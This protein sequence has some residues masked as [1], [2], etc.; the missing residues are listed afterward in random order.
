MSGA[1]M[2]ETQAAVAWER[3]HQ[4]LANSQP[5]HRPEALRISASRD[6]AVSANLAAKLPARLRHAA[7]L[8]ALIDAPEA[9]GI[10]LTVRAAGLRHHAGQI[11]FPGG[12][13]E[14][15]DAGPA[16][17]AMRE[18]QEEVGLDPDHVTV[19]GY[20]ADQAVFTGYRITP[21]VARIAVEFVPR[22]DIGEVRQ[23]FV[24]P[25]ANLLDARSERESVHRIG[26]VDVPVTDLHFGE[27]R[28]WG[29]TA[30]I[31]FA[32]RELACT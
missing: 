9:P 18:A 26:G 28:I 23:T 11:A 27:H 25:W 8:I 15:G 4:R 5:D 31:L 16:A 2:D 10:L 6:V 29:A 19:L 14:A 30:G 17:A 22:L 20:L 12:V 3:L 32:L 24:L 1:V 21:V 13:I 7:V